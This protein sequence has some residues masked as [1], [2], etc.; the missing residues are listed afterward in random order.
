[1]SQSLSEK[2]QPV[3]TAASPFKFVCS[4]SLLCFTQCCRDV[5]IFLTPYDVLRL[6]RSLKIGSGEFLAKYTMHFLA[7]VTNIPVVQFKMN[8][9]TLYCQ[10]VSEAGCTVYEDRPWACRMYPLDLTA[11]E[12]EYRAIV[13]KDRCFGFSEPASWSM[14]EWLKNQ[15]VGPFVEME[16]IY[17]MVMPE[18]FVPGAPMDE[19]LGRLLFLAYDLDRFAKLLDDTRFKTFYQVD[20]ELLKKVRENDEELLKLAYRYIRSQMEELY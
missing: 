4:D 11:K 12:D 8:P 5:N 14:D 13:G 1:M 10:L 7:R 15:G 17:R 20:D 6:R 16:H 9:E 18:R 2:E 19:G 3:F